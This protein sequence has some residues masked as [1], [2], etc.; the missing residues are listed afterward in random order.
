[1]YV[2]GPRGTVVGVRAKID[3]RH[4]ADHRIRKNGSWFHETIA[5]RSDRASQSR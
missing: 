4:P 5:G 2:L 3:I 1:M